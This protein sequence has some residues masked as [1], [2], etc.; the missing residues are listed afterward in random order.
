MNSKFLTPCNNNDNSN[1]NNNNNNNNAFQYTKIR[2]CLELGFR[3]GLWLYLLFWSN[4]L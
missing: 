4:N 3:I 2:L 1:N